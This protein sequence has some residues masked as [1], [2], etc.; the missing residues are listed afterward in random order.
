[1]KE[2]RSFF[3]N[4]R[5]HALRP[6]YPENCVFDL[7]RERF[8]DI[9]PPEAIHFHGLDVVRDSSGT[10]VLYQVNHVLKAGPFGVRS[11]LDAT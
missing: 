10:L 1:M 7:D 8:G 6:A 5:T 9:Q 11:P 3:V 2:A 4:V